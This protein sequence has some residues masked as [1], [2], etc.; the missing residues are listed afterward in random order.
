[1]TVQA[2]CRVPKLCTFCAALPHQFSR[3]NYVANKV[4]YVLKHTIV[5]ISH[6][7]VRIGHDDLPVYN[8]FQAYFSP[9]FRYLGPEVL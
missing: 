1:M 5:S 3:R 4:L 7:H 6:V 9:V 8:V 2:M